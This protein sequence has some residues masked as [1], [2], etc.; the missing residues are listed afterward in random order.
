MVIPKQLAN[1]EAAEASESQ[2]STISY[3]ANSEIFS[4][5]SNFA[6][7]TI[8]AAYPATDELLEKTGLSSPKGTIQLKD[9]AYRVSI[10]LG[11]AAPNNRIYIGSNNN[12][13]IVLI[14]KNI[15][16]SLLDA[17]ARAYI[18]FSLIEE[19]KSPQPWQS[20]HISVQQMGKREQ[21]NEPRLKALEGGAG[22]E[23]TRTNRG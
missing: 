13:E 12:R 6:H 16:D 17:K 18:S 14:Q 9:Q 5:F 4:L 15:V 1:A 11:D 22:V 20:L 23:S 19:L 8:E 21:E 2:T 7:P 3:P 10:S